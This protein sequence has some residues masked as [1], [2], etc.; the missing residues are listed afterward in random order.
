MLDIN[1]LSSYIN[2]TNFCYIDA[3]LNEE[4]IIKDILEKNNKIKFFLIEFD[5]ELPNK[6]KNLFLD[7]NYKILKKKDNNFLFSKN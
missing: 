2:E 7:K 3:F 5:Y 6:I 1:F 4:M